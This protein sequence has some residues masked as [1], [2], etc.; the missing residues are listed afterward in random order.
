VFT[1][2]G[3]DEKRAVNIL[4]HEMVHQLAH[5]RYGPAHLNA[6][7]ILLEGV[8][9]WGAGK[10]WLGG[11]PDFRSYVRAQRQSGISYPLAMSYSGL[12]VAGMNALYYQWA[13][14]VEFLIDTYGRLK[15]D[16]LYVSGN[17]AP[18][19]ADYVGVYG[20]NLDQLQQEWIDW[21]GQ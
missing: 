10:Y 11:A 21:L 6:D 18:G 7:L 3:I 4:A 16:Q 17:S 15:F 19:S 13:S 12:G 2:P 20:K 1:C 8:A 14:F 5:D 9:T